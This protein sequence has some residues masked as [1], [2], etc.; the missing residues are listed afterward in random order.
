MGRCLK[1][2]R[3]PHSHSGCLH[4]QVDL[5]ERIGRPWYQQ[6]RAAYILAPCLASGSGSATGQT[7]RENRSSSILLPGKA[8]FF[9]AIRSAGE[10]SRSDCANVAE[11]A[12][13]CRTS[14]VASGKR[15]WWRFHRGPHHGRRLKKCVVVMPFFTTCSPFLITVSY[16]FIDCSARYAATGKYFAT[17]VYIAGS[18]MSVRKWQECS[19]IFKVILSIN[20]LVL[21]TNKI[22]SVSRLASL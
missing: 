12:S 21:S 16:R 5:Y 1:S 6:F 11:I 19:L 22:S 14:A 3:H 13:T 10:N 4:R 18:S 17:A 15:P 20:C 9:V 7:V 8:Q 2:Q